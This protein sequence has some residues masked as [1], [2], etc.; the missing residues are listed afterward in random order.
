MEKILDVS[1]FTVDK[2]M[3]Q[4]KNEGRERDKEKREAE[5][6]KKIEKEKEAVRKEQASERKKVVEDN[7]A[8]IKKELQ[9]KINMYFDRFPFL[10]EKIPKLSARFTI[11]E[12]EEILFLIRRE[13]DSQNSL[14]NIQNYVNYG[15]MTL[16]A[17]WGDGSRMTFLPQE[18]RLNLKG[19]SSLVQGGTFRDEILPLLMEIDIEYPWLGRR[20]LPMRIVESV[21][22]VLMKT[23]LLNTNPAARRLLNL[24]T[25]SPIDIDESQL[26]EE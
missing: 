3:E 10:S 4:T 12:A 7:E 9:F 20:A 1:E 18:S 21:T 15:A 2:V 23:H 11:S 24:E 5:I 26:S 17:F 19:I 16:E 22:N 25:E 6:L 13:M 8:V 14:R